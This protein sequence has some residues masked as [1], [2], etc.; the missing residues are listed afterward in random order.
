M[1]I[2]ELGA[3]GELVGGVAVIGTLVYLATQVRHASKLARRNAHR[4]INARDMTFDI[5]RD[6]ELHHFWFTSLSGEQELSEEEQNRFGLLLYSAFGNL[7]TAYRFSAWDPGIASEAQNRLDRFLR[8][9]R[10]REWWSRQRGFHAEPFRSWVDA[11]L[12]HL[13][14]LS[15]AANPEEA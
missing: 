5:G 15:G 2:L 1:N 4:E 12:N 8:V 6:A 11:R 10:V 3:I 13:Q 9:P 7:N 14:T